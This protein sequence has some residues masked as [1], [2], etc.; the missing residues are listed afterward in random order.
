[1]RGKVLAAGLVGFAIAMFGW[2]GV[3]PA[4]ASP[5]CD[6]NF[7][8]D[9]DGKIDYDGGPGLLGQTTAPDPDCSGPSDNSEATSQCSLC[10]T[11]VTTWDPDG[12][13]GTPAKTRTHQGLLVNT[14]YSLDVNGNGGPVPTGVALPG[15]EVK[16]SVSALSETNPTIRI[17]KLGTAPPTL[18]LRIELVNGEAGERQSI[19]Y[20]TLDSTAPG[21][22]AAKLDLTDRDA[23]PATD[24]VHVELSVNNP[25]RRLTVVNEDYQSPEPSGPKSE[26]HIRR[27]TFVGDP[28]RGTVVPTNST[29]DITTSTAA[30]TIE[31]AHSQRTTLEFLL[32]EP[33]TG[34]DVNGRVDELP[35]RAELTLSDPDLNGDSEGDTQVDYTA[36][37]VAG[38]VDVNLVSPGTAED[39]AAKT[40]H[41]TII[42]LPT[43]AHLT[44]ASLEQGSQSNTDVTYHANSRATSTTVA[45]VTNDPVDG[46]SSFAAAV[47]NVPAN[48]DELSFQSSP[49]TSDLTYAADAIADHAHVETHAPNDNFLVDVE[50]LPAEVGLNFESPDSGIQLEY[51]GSSVVPF[52]HVNQDGLIAADP[53]DPD[54]FAHRSETDVTVS[55]ENMPGQGLPTHLEFR[56][57]NDEGTTEY[58]AS[59]RIPK[60]QVV[61]DDEKPLFERANHLDL[62]INDLAPAVN[63]EQRIDFIEFDA[64][65]SQVGLVELLANSQGDIERL[66]SAEDGVLLRDTAD[67]YT[68][69]GRV[70][71]LR[72]MTYVDHGAT[73]LT[74]DFDATPPTGTDARLD[75]LSDIHRTIW[76]N[77]STGEDEEIARDGTDETNV[78]LR[79][80]PADIHIDMDSGGGNTFL[81]YTAA[82]AAGRFDIVQETRFSGDPVPVTYKYPYTDERLPDSYVP[83]AFTQ[84]T[85]GALIPMPAS[86]HIC[87]VP[88][89]AACSDGTW[90]RDMFEDFDPATE[91]NGGSTRFTA[92]PRTRFVFHDFD[93]GTSTPI[94]YLRD[95]DEVADAEDPCERNIANFFCAYSEVKPGFSTKDIDL[96]LGDLI[97]QSH[98]ESSGWVGHNIADIFADGDNQGYVAFDTG[99]RDVESLSGSA[100]CSAL[101][102]PDY[103]CTVGPPFSS[104]CESL[105]PDCGAL[106]GAHGHLPPPEEATISG[107]V[108]KGGDWCLAGDDCTEIED[109]F[110]LGFGGKVD[111]V[112]LGFGDPFGASHRV[113]EFDPDELIFAIH[114]SGHVYCNSNTDLRAGGTSIT[115]K[116]CELSIPPPE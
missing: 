107:T 51:D 96:T 37:Q 88:K 87:Q 100:L 44:L 23:N 11:F 91:A 89:G 28:A 8:N 38:R 99:W 70:R 10:V 9:L 78:L 25:G 67:A 101:D 26:R 63:L 97:I 4:D 52:A 73:A 21:A 46:I 33:G 105:P 29:L 93:G 42:G 2:I 92:S 81:D 5:R 86:F 18:P 71:G 12:P 61:I 59:G 27:L 49:N 43:E 16:V 110:P 115:D 35:S 36:S 109:S 47:V 104:A 50:D 45:T 111:A 20:D 108:A 112:S 64:H 75:L 77:T 116:I 74:V 69:F 53:T 56:T 85:N 102:E 32:D 114:H 94:A 103:V 22:F 83:A 3:A 6:D 48:V 41:A 58:I 39:P 15:Y 19:G 31:I 62:L 40:T 98:L 82:S 90:E 113:F 7:D 13:G 17:T 80:Y 55:G 106:F 30:Q 1:M 14:A 84:F 68:L 65:G 95:F 72:S 76:T 60:I 57:N 34:T 24:Q 66:P 79:D 54:D